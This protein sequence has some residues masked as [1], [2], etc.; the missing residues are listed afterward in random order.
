[1]CRPTFAS[2]CDSAGK[3]HQGRLGLEPAQAQQGHVHVEQ[4]APLLRGPDHALDQKKLAMRAPRVTGVTWC[5][6]V[7]G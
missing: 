1:M 3:L 5:S 7:P 2:G 6:V 4:Q